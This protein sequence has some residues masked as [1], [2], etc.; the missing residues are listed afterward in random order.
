MTFS[1]T[2]LRITSVLFTLALA[3]CPA[4]SMAAGPT[5]IYAASQTV[6]KSTDGGLNWTTISPNFSNIFAL[7]IDPT[8]ASVIYAGVYGGIYKTKNG[9]T[10]WTELT[11]TIQSSGST[12][13]AIA[14]DPSNPATIYAG[15][16]GAI[17]NGGVYKSTDSGAHWTLMNNGLV[18]NGI[19][20]VLALAIDPLNTQTIYVTGNTGL[21]SAVSTNGAASWQPLT[22]TVPFGFS[23]AINPVQPSIVYMSGFPEVTESTNSGGT[24]STVLSSGTIFESLAIDPSTPTTI[25]AGT[26]GCASNQPACIYKTTNGGTNWSPVGSI[27]SQYAN[28]L[29]ID[30]ANTATIYA[31]GQNGVYQSPDGGVTWNLVYSATNITSLAMQPNA[32]QNAFFNAVEAGVKDV[33]AA[34]GDIHNTAID[35]AVLQE[36]VNTIHAFVELGFL[37][38]T[39][40]QALTMQLQTAMQSVP[41]Q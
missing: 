39:Q 2:H 8:N 6:I 20:S 24:W 11:N 36:S 35:C 40:G 18:T 17:G 37:S 38:A 21:Q 27:A 13:D 29:A 28:A 15:T 7:A 41:C 19:F 9:G 5:T 33:I 23:I 16:G 34:V 4:I 12:V 25:Y 30:P 14:I 31:G 3:V 32:E 22:G 10:S 26:S 1:T